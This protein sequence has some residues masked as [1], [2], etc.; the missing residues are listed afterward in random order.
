MQVQN[1]EKDGIVGQFF[2]GYKMDLSRVE[3]VIG[4]DAIKKLQS[5]AVAVVGLGGVGSYVAE[6]LARSGIGN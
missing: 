3:I 4:K 1:L 5:A 6:S 2:R